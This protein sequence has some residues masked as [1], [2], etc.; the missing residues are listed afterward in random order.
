MFP[1]PFFGFEHALDP[2][3]GVGS[4]AYR[5]NAQGHWAGHQEQQGLRLCERTQLRSVINQKR[6][7]PD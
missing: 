6:G 3:G 5:I 2:A 7:K 4:C 1:G